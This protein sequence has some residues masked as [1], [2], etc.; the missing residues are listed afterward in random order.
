MRDAR[1]PSYPSPYKI[2]EPVAGNYYPVN[3]LASISDDCVEFDVIVDTSLATWK[4]TRPG[5]V[6]LHAI[7]ATATLAFIS[8]QRR[9]ALEISTQVPRVRIARVHGPPP[10]PGGRQPGRAGTVK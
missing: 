4:S 10:P 2:S 3:A 1:G 9:L 5:T 8:A 7:D 6:D